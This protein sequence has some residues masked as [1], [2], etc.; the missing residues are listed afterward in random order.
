MFSITTPLELYTFISSVSSESSDILTSLSRN[1]I[2]KKCT[3]KR[4]SL[5]L[6]YTMEKKTHHKMKGA[7]A[8]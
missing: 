1:C 7:R 3:T 5:A 4:S 8:Q 2:H 6:Y